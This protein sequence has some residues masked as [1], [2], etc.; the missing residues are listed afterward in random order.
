MI[1]PMDL[2]GKKVLVTGGSSGIGR[3]TCIQLSRLGA[4]VIMIARNE[5]KLNQTLDQMEGD[6]HLLFK[7]DLY[8]INGIESFMKNLI[9][10]T[11]AL[12]GLVHCAGIAP[13]RPLNMTTNKFL[14]DIFVINVYAFIEL[15]RLFAKKGNFNPN[16][17]IVV[18]SST[19]SFQGGKTK[20][21]YSASKGALNSAVKSMAVELADKKIRVNT[22]CPS[23]VE[24]ALLEEYT[25]LVG[26]EARIKQLEKQYAGYIPS[27]S[28]ANAIAYLLSKTSEHITGTDFIID[29][30]ATSH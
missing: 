11:G 4:Q 20:I 26:E 1:N 15:S 6:N 12:D 30:G 21:A 13:M 3:A 8:D 5:Q 23:F 22:V 9:S 25:T 17:S 19:A 28:V 7:F 27:E 29:A 10:E 24:T 14:N 18:M 16:S 2:S